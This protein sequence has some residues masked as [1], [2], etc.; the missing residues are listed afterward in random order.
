MKYLGKAASLGRKKYLKIQQKTMG[1][2]IQQQQ[3][4][5]HK[6]LS[7]KILTRIYLGKAAKLGKKN[8]ITTKHK[9]QTNT[10]DKS[11]HQEIFGKSCKSW[12]RKLFGDTQ[13]PLLLLIQTTSVVVQN[14]AEI[15]TVE[16]FFIL[17]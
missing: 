12:Q 7:I 5:G 3:N 4:K 1:K 10:K 8:T 9:R 11:S 6:K 2:Q 17:K 15:R 13:S 16:M 14:R